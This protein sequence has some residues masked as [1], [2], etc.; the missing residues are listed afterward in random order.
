MS[1]T[2]G[3]GLLFIAAA[4]VTVVLGTLLDLQIDSVFF[5]LTIGAILAL[6]NDNSSALGRLGGFAVGIVVTMA[7]YIIRVLMLNESLLGQILFAI[8]VALLITAICGL[9]RGHLPLWSGLTGAA[10]VVGSYEASFLQ[11]PQ[12]I[13]TNLIAS[14]SMALVPMAIAFIAGIL[15]RPEI[16]RDDE[17][18]NDQNAEARDEAPTQ[19]TQEQTTTSGV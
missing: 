2:F 8:I 5:G 1:K 9:T 10:L 11:A 7:G 4:I 13:T 17:D 6:V 12:D 16:I 14:V 18:Q 3:A 15:I 19:S